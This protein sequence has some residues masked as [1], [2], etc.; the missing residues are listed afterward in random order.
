[1]QSL[2]PLPIHKYQV[3]VNPNTIMP[4]VVLHP[5]STVFV[6]GVNG[7]I[8]SHIADQLL[9][10]GYHVRGAVRSIQKNNWLQAHF[11]GKHE[12]AK[13]SLV[14]VPDMAADGCYDN[15]LQGKKLHTTPVAAPDCGTNRRARF[16]P[17]S[18]ADE[19]FCRFICSYLHWC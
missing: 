11:D 3:Y 17:R 10:S 8:G 16:H 13:F 2:T 19:R 15:V 9:K 12:G 5:G 18:V 7:L 14:E 1:V 6:T 4:A